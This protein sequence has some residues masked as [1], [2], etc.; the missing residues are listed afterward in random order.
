MCV[1]EDFLAASL[2]YLPDVQGARVILEGRVELV[3]ERGFERVNPDPAGVR[4][5][6]D[7]GRVVTPCFDVLCQCLEA[8]EAATDASACEFG[9]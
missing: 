8:T 6:W 7:A 1:E 4:R 2:L 3:L 9:G 5:N